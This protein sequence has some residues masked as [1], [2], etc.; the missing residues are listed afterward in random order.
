[1]P[2]NLLDILSN[3]ILYSTIFDHLEPQDVIRL[4]QTCRTIYGFRG[5]LWNINRSLRRF[6]DDPI[7]F[8]TLMAQHD[9]IVS[10]SHALQFLARVKWTKSDLDVYITKDESLVAFANHL[11]TNEGY[12]FKPYEWQSPD[13]MKAIRDRKS[14]QEKWVE[15]LMNQDPPVITDDNMSELGVYTLKGITGV[16]NFIHPKSENRRI[17]LILA[18]VTPLYA[19]LTGYYATHIFNFFTWNR[20]YSLFPY[21][22]FK[23][24]DAY[25]TQGL[26]R[27]AGQGVEKYI[28]RGYEFLEY[29]KF[30]KCIKNCPFRPHRRVADQFSW[31]LDLDTEGIDGSLA[32]VPQ[33]VIEYQTWGMKMHT[34]YWDRVDGVRVFVPSFKMDIKIVCDSSG[35]FRYPRIYDYQ[36]RTWGNY[37]S[38]MKKTMGRLNGYHIGFPESKSKDWGDEDGMYRFDGEFE[39]WYKLWEK[40]IMPYENIW[41]WQYPMLGGVE[42]DVTFDGKEREVRYDKMQE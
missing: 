21:H 26:T 2:L 29:G 11:M 16:F 41:R 4:S 39:N 5:D 38:D 36:N 32:A 20:A 12:Y 24:K 25:Y 14:E 40:S 13:A 9:A 34:S 1:M 17:Q 28:E 10:G 31:V 8:R 30:H 37:I 15:K 22:T 3:T 42:P 35:S 6:V 19:V 27:Q 33:S 7:A 18:S 23:D